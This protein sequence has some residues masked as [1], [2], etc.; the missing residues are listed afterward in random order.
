MKEL[1]A[2][3]K[4]TGYPRAPRF[5]IIKWLTDYI[6][7][8]GIDGYRADTVR[9]IEES[10][11]LEFKKECD[12]SFN[13]WKKNNPEKVLDDNSFYLVGEVY[14]YEIIKNGTEFDFGDKKVDYYAN[15][16]TSMI[17]FE[18]KG[19]ANESYETIFSRYSE[20]L[21]GDLKGKGI[22]NYVS[23][24]DDSYPFD[25]ERKKPF[26]SATK[27][28][29]SPGTT[30]VYYGDE[31]ARTLIVDGT[32]GDATLR[33]MMDWDLIANDDRSNAILEHWQKL[34]KFRRDHPSIGAGVH[35]M[36]SEDPYIFSRVLQRENISDAVI[37][38][39]DLPKGKKEIDVSS[40]FKN[41]DVLL[42]KYSNTEVEV[43]GG[44]LII[45]SEF[46]I[47]LMEMK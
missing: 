30:Q 24:H 27:L 42:D 22:L 29:L 34:G 14:G 37:V 21:H 20:A 46:D 6:K 7:D 4:R 18:F 8:Y 39:L 12:Y 19:N 43:K 5:Y 28:L 10:V 45:D 17:N 41:G 40:V 31:V 11:W 33:S 47:V 1:D 26:E 2:F 25:M 32:N 15:G 38:G 9:H 35:K 36:I 16:F 23:S 44:K 3:F 13:L